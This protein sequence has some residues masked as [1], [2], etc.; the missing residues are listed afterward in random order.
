MVVYINS[1]RKHCDIIV[2]HNMACGVRFG[3]KP[4]KKLLEGIT[5]PA[6]IYDL[7]SCRSHWL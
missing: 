3:G 7:D 5:R 1:Y 4:N 6:G 2:S